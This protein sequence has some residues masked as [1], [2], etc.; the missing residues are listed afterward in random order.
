MGK[1]REFWIGQRT[2]LQN[3]ITSHVE[4]LVE[5]VPVEGFTHV[6]EH[7][8]YL[9]LQQQLAKAK[10]EL[11]VA[12][13]SALRTYDGLAQKA[14]KADEFAKQISQLQQELKFVKADKSV[15]NFDAFLK[16]KSE[17]TASQAQLVR[18]EEALRFYSDE[19]FI[20]KVTIGG[21]GYYEAW[22]ND[23]GKHAREYFKAKDGANT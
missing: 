12:K 18:A 13:D 14:D 8:A 6:I 10:A 4:F 16:L 3:G 15:D 22:E 23:K 11:W 7:S 1:A 5:Q 21:F 19:A 2:M 9:E 20:Q 17:L